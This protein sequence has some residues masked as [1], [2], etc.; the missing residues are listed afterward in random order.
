MFYTL[1]LQRITRTYFPPA[2]VPDGV[3]LGARLAVVP[4]V[5]RP[6]AELPTSHLHSQEDIQ[7]RAHPLPIP[8]AVSESFL[9]HI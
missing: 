6:S 8:A 7:E 2:A 5:F 9:C 3:R 4:A 1:M